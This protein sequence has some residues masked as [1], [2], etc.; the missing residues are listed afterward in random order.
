MNNITENK[1]LNAIKFFVK[2]TNN[3]GRTKL[4]KLLYFL[5]FMF[6]KEYGLSVTL[7]DYYTFPFG[8]VPKQLFDQI[9]N[10]NLPDF[11]KNE[12][13]FME[14]QNEENEDEYKQFKA[15]LKNPKIDLSCFAPYEKEMLEKVTEIFK[16]ASAKDIT[17][18]SHLKNHP[19]D[20]TKN[21]RGMFQKIDYELAIDEDSEL[22]IDDVKEYLELQKEL[23][24][25]E[26]LRKKIK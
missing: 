7:Y 26:N 16:Y 20:K 13:F 15:V 2:N 10:D 17:E 4:F 11:L 25:I 14:E 19:W 23:S 12:I 22:D 21:S 9:A 1:I 5:D 18:A 24:Y 8:P 6:F 3:V